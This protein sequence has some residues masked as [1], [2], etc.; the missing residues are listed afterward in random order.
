M[1][2][3]PIVNEDD[4][5][6]AMDE[7]DRLCDAELEPDE[8]DYLEALAILVEN[9]EV[10]HYPFAKPD[11]I[12]AI[13]HSME[14]Q[15]LERKDLEPFIGSRAR[16]SEILNRRRH[17]TLAMIRNLEAGLGIPAEVLIT[18]YELA[19][20]ECQPRDY[21]YIETDTSVS[22]DTSADKIIEQPTRN[23]QTHAIYGISKA[24]SYKLTKV[25][26]A[27]T[28]TSTYNP[29]AGACIH[30]MP[31]HNRPTKSHEKR[32]TA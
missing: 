26:K 24:P 9:Y 30:E 21:E 6:W 28:D 18:P 13:K 2:L 4:Y 27:F 10:K 19:E 20:P 15:G 31:S 8:A 32:V 1:E 3:K 16:I 14:A 11:P 25:Q 12:E 23:V 22:P 29:L 17:L 5:N 7:M